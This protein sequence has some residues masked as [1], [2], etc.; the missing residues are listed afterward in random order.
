MDVYCRYHPTHGANWQCLGCHVQLCGSCVPVKPGKGAA[1][2]PLCQQVMRYSAEGSAAEVTPFWQRLNDFFAYPMAR[3]PMILVAICTLVPLALGKDLISL[4]IAI[5]LFCAQVKY[6]YSVI[7][8]T[9]KG[10]LKP[11]ELL[12]A[13]SGGGLL[14]VIQQTLIF[15]AFGALI[16]VSGIWGGSFLMILA[17]AFSALVLPASIMLLAIEGNVVDALHPTRL[18]GF[19]SSIGWPYFVLYGY[20]L[21]LFLGLGAAQDFVLSNFSQTLGF[22]LAGFISSYFMLVIFNMLGYLLFQYQHRLG[23]APDEAL[24]APPQNPEALAQRNDKLA[25][26]EIDINLKEGRYEAAA[27]L[28]RNLYKR[29]PHDLVVLDRLYKLLLET[30]AWP[31]LLKTSKPVLQML[32]DAGRI[33]EL[34]LVLRGLYGHFPDYTINDETLLYNVAQS[35]YHSGDFRLTLKL[36]QGFNSRF[37]ESAHAADAIIVMARTLANGLHRADKAKEYLLYVQKHYPDHS[38]VPEIPAWIEAMAK[39]G[40]LPEPVA[41]FGLSS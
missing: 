4:I 33:H 28:L 36:L 18:I 1:T 12:S 16:V 34:K 10:V 21:L 22:P 23:L 15:I 32:A 26:A 24:D 7:E 25:M 5:A 39:N 30:N 27:G 13:F 11:P 17:V 38:A 14:L 35:L 9:S 37:P 29:K 31:E 3:D 6:M 40:R 2:C 8:T 19:I 41:K 20:L